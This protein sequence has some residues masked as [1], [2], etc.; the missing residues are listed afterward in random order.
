MGK[1]KQQACFLSQ[2]LILTRRSFLNMFRDRGYYWLRLVIYIALGFGL[3]TVFFDVG[4]SYSSIQVRYISSS[5]S[6]FSCIQLTVESSGKRLHADV[7]RVFLDH[8]GDRR[9]SFFCGG[10]EGWFW[11]WV[12]L[13]FHYQLKLALT[14]SY[15][16]VTQ[17]EHTQKQPSLWKHMTE[18]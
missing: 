9:L 4:F 2:C 17:H 12:W 7:R 5:S 18:R 8:L 10:H 13:W 6:C 3:G 16:T 14:I 1:Q 15:A 11:F